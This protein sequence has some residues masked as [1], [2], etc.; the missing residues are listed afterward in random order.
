[1]TSCF[2]VRGVS[3]GNVLCLECEIEVLP[4]SDVVSVDFLFLVSVRD[5]MPLILHVRAERYRAA[6]IYFFYTGSAKK[7]IHRCIQCQYRTSTQ[8]VQFTG[9]LL[10]L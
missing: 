6:D 1:M 3:V 9:V 10:C 7:C 5:C 8:L 2:Q 4:N